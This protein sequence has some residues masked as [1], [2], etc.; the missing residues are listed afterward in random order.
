[1][2]NYS[3]W[4]TCSLDDLVDLFIGV[5]GG[6][7]STNPMF[8][9]KNGAVRIGALKYGFASSPDLGQVR[10]LQWQG[11]RILGGGEDVFFGRP[12]KRQRTD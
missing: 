10:P 5:T 12:W 2:L 11:S 4:G 3:R 6:L 7:A 8:K 9:L 1:M